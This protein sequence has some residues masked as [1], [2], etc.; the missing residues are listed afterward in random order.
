MCIQRDPRHD[1]GFAFSLV[2]DIV[3]PPP[4]HFPAGLEE[5]D[6]TGILISLRADGPS[7]PFHPDTAMQRA[8]VCPLP[9]MARATVPMYGR[10]GTAPHRMELG[11]SSS[12]RGQEEQG[13]SLG[14]FMG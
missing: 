9:S 13:V 11:F 12:Q 8:T 14:T 2:L 10:T 4:S 7:F 1:G 6:G 3:N 5:L